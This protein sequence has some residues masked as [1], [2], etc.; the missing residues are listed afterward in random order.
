MDSS[1]Y[2]RRSERRPNFKQISLVNESDDDHGDD[3]DYEEYR[4]ITG[5]GGGG[6][7]SGGG[8]SHNHRQRG[9]YTT[10]TGRKFDGGRGSS[11]EGEKRTYPRR[12]RRRNSAF[13]RDSKYNGLDKNG[14]SRQDKISQDKNL[15]RKKFEGFI[16]IKPEDYPA[17]QPQT[18]IRYLKDGKLYRAGGIVVFN[19]YPKYM[20][21][22]STDGNKVKWTCSFEGKNVYFKK[23]MEA[24]KKLKEKKDKLYQG[25]MDG[26]YK[27][28][29]KEEY[30][31]YEK[32][33][34]SR[35]QSD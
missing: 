16:R 1:S 20:L 2:Q 33:L 12:D 23:D 3:I 28:L 21:L 22:Q 7:G 35:E 15:I 6:G 4:R 17:I 34:A 18:Y 14:M 19:K 24:I 11:A 32:Y 29:S 10:S 25:L 5:G 30:L 9:S 26:E 8:D 31:E 27:L 13:D